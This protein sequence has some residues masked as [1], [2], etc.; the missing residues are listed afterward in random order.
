MLHVDDRD[1]TLPELYSIALRIVQLPG[2]EQEF[3]LGFCCH[4]RRAARHNYSRVQG[5]SA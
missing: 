1:S 5:R 4:I 3:K 2:C